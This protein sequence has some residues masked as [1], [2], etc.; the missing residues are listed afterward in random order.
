[1]VQIYWYHKTPIFCRISSFFFSFQTENIKVYEIRYRTY[2]EVFKDTTLNLKLYY[3][4]LPFEN[5]LLFQYS[6]VR[7]LTLITGIF[8]SGLD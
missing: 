6:E 4:I 2:T 8:S 1:M 5:P 3:I 7:V